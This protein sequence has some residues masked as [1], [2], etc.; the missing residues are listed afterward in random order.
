MDVSNAGFAQG[1]AGMYW[2]DDRKKDKFIGQLALN[3][4]YRFDRKSN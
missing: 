2:V 1:K 4:I 3:E